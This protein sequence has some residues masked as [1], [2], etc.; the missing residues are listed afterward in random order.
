MRGKISKKEVEMQKPWQEFED[1]IAKALSG[2][3]TPGSGNRRIKGD[4]A[5]NRFLVECKSTES[6]FMDVNTEWFSKIKE[7]CL[8]N[9][10]Y[11]AIPVVALGF[12]PFEERSTVLFI[13]YTGGLGTDKDL[14]SFGSFRISKRALIPG[15]KYLLSSGPW[16][17]FSIREFK[18]L[19]ERLQDA[20]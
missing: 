19:L 16:V 15:V 5:G 2:K 7:A 14:S 9:G 18:D 10:T 3:K 6:E 12:A 13:P 20:Q 11:T 8:E 1:F 17:A 4:I